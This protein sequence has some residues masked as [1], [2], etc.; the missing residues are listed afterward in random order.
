MN[1][2]SSIVGTSGVLYS[3]VII[4]I[5]KCIWHLF[6]AMST[7]IV[8]HLL[9]N[10]DVLCQSKFSCCVHFLPKININIYN[11]SQKQTHAA[12]EIRFKQYK[13][14]TNETWYNLNL[15]HMHI[16]TEMSRKWKRTTL[17]KYH[18]QKKSS[19]QKLLITHH[20]IKRPFIPTYMH[21]IRVQWECDIN[22]YTTLTAYVKW[23]QD[24]NT[25]KQ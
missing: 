11:N 9:C 21:K 16:D 3:F 13:H 14:I 25:L 23:I 2:L 12:K 20:I 19:V 8:V 15:A 18:L 17:Q 5:L 10:F 1:L 22:M 24:V 6:L 7:Q 4:S